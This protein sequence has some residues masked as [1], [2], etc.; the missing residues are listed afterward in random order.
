ME[1]PNAET[2]N[3][4]ATAVDLLMKAKSASFV[5]EGAG[6]KYFSLEGAV[7]GETVAV[8]TTQLCYYKQ[9]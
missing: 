6:S 7:G 1:Q 9:P 8:P 3:L 5:Y 4:L 2:E